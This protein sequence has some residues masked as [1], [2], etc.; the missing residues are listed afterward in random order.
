MHKIQEKLLNLA[1]Q[2]SELEGQREIIEEQY[3]LIY[4]DFIMNEYFEMTKE[5]INEE[6]GK[7]D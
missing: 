6:D 3:Q 2:L 7:E 5:P 1:K 4:K